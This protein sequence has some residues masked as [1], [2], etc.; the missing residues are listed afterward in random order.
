[1]SYLYFSVNPFIS[2]ILST[3][4]VPGTWKA[5]VNKINDK[6]CLLGPYILGK[7]ENKHD[8]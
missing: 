5:E 1:M 3:Y 6:L 8:K 2:Q 4:F 7:L